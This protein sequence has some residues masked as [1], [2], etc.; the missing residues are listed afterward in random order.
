M[1]ALQMVIERIT[2]TCCYRLYNLYVYSSPLMHR[3][4]DGGGGKGR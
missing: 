3:I 4:E 1:Q 2:I